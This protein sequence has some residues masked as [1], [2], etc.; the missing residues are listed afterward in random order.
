MLKL[1]LIGNLGQDAEVK[2]IESGQLITFSVAATTSK[3][4]TSVWVSCSKFV[5]HGESTAIAQ[6]LKKGGKVF[7]EGLPSVEMYTNKQGV[8]VANMKCMVN[9]IEL[10][11]SVEPRT[12]QTEAKPSNE[13]DLPF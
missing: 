6:Y 1:Q 12:P 9:Q 8:Q 10:L 7:V 5:K 4:D 11:G 3:K 13:E 2:Q